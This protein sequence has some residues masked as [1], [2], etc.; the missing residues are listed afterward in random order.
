MFVVMLGTS[1]LGRLGRKIAIFTLMRAL[2]VFFFLL[3]VIYV[4]DP[5]KF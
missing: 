4:G 5:Q 1:R 2:A 3:I